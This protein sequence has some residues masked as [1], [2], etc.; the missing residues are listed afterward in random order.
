MSMQIYTFFAH[1][2]KLWLNLSCVIK[3]IY[4]DNKITVR[5]LC[6]ISAKPVSKILL[7]SVD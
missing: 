2:E 7:Q 6:S 1:M 3:S 5:L 4:V